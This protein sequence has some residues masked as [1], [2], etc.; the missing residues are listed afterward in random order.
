MGIPTLTS[1]TPQFEAFLPEHPFIVVNSEDLPAKLEQVIPDKELRR[2]KSI[3]GRQFVDN[4]HR[5]EKV[6]ESIY[7]LYREMGWVDD[8]GN[9]TA[10]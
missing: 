5:A 4:Y 1:F 9:F 2:R 8:E 3:E 7:A 10:S 6:T